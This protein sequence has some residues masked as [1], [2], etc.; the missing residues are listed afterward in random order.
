MSEISDKVRSV[1]RVTGPEW[2]I[3]S[4]KKEV[5]LILG[6]KSRTALPAR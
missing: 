5:R 3:E 4:P 2:E 1:E 6:R